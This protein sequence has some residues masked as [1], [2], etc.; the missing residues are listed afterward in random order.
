VDTVTSVVSNEGEYIPTNGKGALILKDLP[1]NDR[2]R[3][4]NWESNKAGVRG[5]I[6]VIDAA[7]GSKAIRDGAEVLYTVL[8]D[9]LISSI[10]PNLLIF[11]NKQDLPTAKG[12]KVI[13]PALE[14]EM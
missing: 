6:C 3:Q 7:G 1:G 8:T 4:K 12:I 14:R 9:P 10:R 13:R 5:I 2:V 11:A